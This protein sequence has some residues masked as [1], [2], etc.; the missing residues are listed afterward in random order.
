MACLLCS[1][2]LFS[3]VFGLRHAARVDAV[4]I[5]DW[6]FD[7]ESQESGPGFNSNDTHCNIPSLN[8][9]DRVRGQGGKR[10]KLHS[11]FSFLDK[12]KPGATNAESRWTNES[13]NS[14]PPAN[15]AANAAPT[16][17]CASAFPYSDDSD[18]GS[19][20]NSSEFTLNE[21]YE[22][23]NYDPDKDGYVIYCY[24][25]NATTK[26]SS[27]I[28]GAK[29]STTEAKAQAKIIKWR[30]RVA[31]E[32]AR[33]GVQPA[34][35]KGKYVA[36]PGR[37]PAQPRSVP[38]AGGQWVWESNLTKVKDNPPVLKTDPLAKILI[39][40][41]TNALG[42]EQFPDDP[43]VLITALNVIRKHINISNGPQSAE[44][45]TLLGK[46][47]ESAGG[48]MTSEQRKH[49][50]QTAQ[51]IE[52]IENMLPGNVVAQQRLATTVHQR[53]SNETDTAT[54]D[55]IIVDGLELFLQTQKART[56]GRYTTEE[57]I[58]QQAVTS[59]AVASAPNGSLRA[60]SRRLQVKPA[61][62]HEA[63]DRWEAYEANETTS[64]I[65]LN[66]SSANAYPAAFETFVVEAWGHK[67]RKSERMKDDIHNPKDR[68]DLT[69]YRV[70]WRE[71][72]ITDL[73][74][75]VLTEGIAYFAE[76]ESDVQFH[77]S[78]TKF[79]DLKPFW[80]K[81]PGRETCLCRYHMGFAHYATS[82]HQFRVT[83]KSDP[84]VQ[85]AC[86][87]PNPKHWV[88]ARRQL[89]CPRGEDS[90][91]DRPECVNSTC[92][93][94]DKLHNLT[95]CESEMKAIGLPRVT[96]EQSVKTIRYEK[97][98]K[99]PHGYIKMDNTRKDF[100]DFVKQAPTP[101]D[102]FEKE[103]EVMSV[104]FLKHH[105]L[106]RWQDND[107]AVTQA[108]FPRGHFACVQD[109]SENYHHQHRLEHQSKY[110]NEISS[111]VYGCVVRAHLADLSDEFIGG[112]ARRAE[113]MA[114]FTKN[115]IDDDIVTFTVVAISADRHH[116]AAFVKT[117]NIRLIKFMQSITSSGAKFTA[118]H[119][120]SDGCKAQ[121]KCAQHF[122]FVST[123]LSYWEKY[124]WQYGC[125]VD[126]C[127]SCSCHGK[128]LSDP[129]CGRC[130]H[131]ARE[132]EG[133]DNVDHDTKLRDS[134]EYYKFLVKNMSTLDRTIEQ[135]KMKGIWKRVFW[136]VPTKGEGSVNRRV[137]AIDTLKGSSD[138]HQ[139][140]DIG[141]PGKLVVRERSCH[142]CA[143]CFAGDFDDCANEG[144]VG[145]PIDATLKVISPERDPVT[146]SSLARTGLALADTVS[147]GD[148]IVVE[149]HSEQEPWIVCRALGAKHTHALASG[150]IQTRMGRVI[151]G[152]VLVNV[153]KLEGV[154]SSYKVIGNESFPV[155]AEDIR[156]VK[157]LMKKLEPVRRQP[158][159]HAA[160]VR[161]DATHQFSDASAAVERFEMDTDTLKEILEQMPDVNDVPVRS[162]V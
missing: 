141:T 75:E 13:H 87:C 52:I 157:F 53:L 73:Y 145:A 133:R 113:L 4:P 88:D 58:A 56:E 132:Y 1:L 139:F 98:E 89:V 154:G 146:R 103:F 92:S 65:V 101:F 61:K 68:K 14:T 67:T 19:D 86:S 127:F 95:L 159:R 152:D 17:V 54:I 160:R 126:W 110:F 114:A 44:V 60:I 40:D 74:A 25:N 63:L 37:P 36:G 23:C 135:K 97:W 6:V 27:I 123:C 26:L 105:D 12:P 153:E 116:D 93:Q 41:L 43:A 35:R 85:S 69:L 8:L 91:F 148:F 29:N 71:D 11:A 51:I 142:E 119:A 162:T 70:H 82:R 42:G 147:N 90:K 55:K 107:W 31:R 64:V 144:T 118:M 124:G 66:E 47:R 77:L 30:E 134:E 38:R 62:V 108:T 39:R 102:V 2:H 155:F 57:R 104:D 109:F 149:Q 140:Q 117:F 84:G 151:P 161:T 111:T 125:K 16:T 9:E 143:C 99:D 22:R 136:Y 34:T 5:H 100:Y 83:L 33:T 72:R 156:L 3:T 130:K 59:A 7:V 79:R 81:K 20:S 21:D 18:S 78:E 24:I 131:A 46:H 28:L 137:A 94:C 49:K 120:R 128:D 76:M 129:E 45:L 10:Q 50:R 150:E 115:A 15:A 96:E 121:Y 48:N 112:A 106:A 122:M 138:L 80:V 158:A 32:T